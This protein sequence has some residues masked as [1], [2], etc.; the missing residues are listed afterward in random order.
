MAKR[1][2]TM[3]DSNKELAERKLKLLR[4]RQSLMEDLPHLYGW[5]WYKWAWDFFNSTNR[6]T[7][8]CA[9]NQISKSS[10]QIR[11]CIDWATNQEKWPSLWGRQ[12]NQFWYLYPSKEVATIEFEKKWLPEF[13]PRGAQKNSPYYGWTV[14]YDKKY[15]KA[16]HF[17]SGV[18]VY[19]KT[20][21]QDP[22]TL[23]SGSVYAIFCDEELPEH[24]YDELKF[25]LAG[26]RGFFH[27]VFTATLGQEMW[28]RAMEAIGNDNELFDTAWKRTISMYDCQTY[29]DGS[30]GPWTNERI[31][32]VIA[33][34]KSQAE[35]LRRVFGRFI[36][37]EGR[38][39]HAFDPTKHYVKPFKIPANWDRRVGVDIGSGGEEAHPSA[40]TFIAIRPDYQYGVIYKGW[41][42][43]GIQTTSGDV[44]DKFLEMKEPTEQFVNKVYDFAAKD[45]GT[46]TQRL[47]DS[48]N[49]AEKSHELGEDIINTLFK[50]N[51]LQIFDT[52]ELRK[53]G[54]EM[55]TLQ[56]STP[57]TKAKD[58]F[59]DS[60]RYPI[61]DAP[62]DFTAITP[63]D[64]SKVEE[65]VVKM[66]K[67][68][69]E[70][71]EYY[72]EERRKGFY[73]QRTASDDNWEYSLE[74]DVA[75]WNEQYGN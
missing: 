57:K 15:V 47:G 62:W 49:K 28:W 45:F 6:M 58:D 30:E 53:L 17:R 48:W 34:C 20:Y 69:Q 2:A 61:V 71:Q 19:F 64:D 8:L 24:L 27:M 42:G 10:T 7:L 68:A 54:N 38:K 22:K 14:E 5:P 4:E 43:D 33:D 63:Q 41:R 21:M 25:R 9:A 59:C 65:K 44:Y 66:P 18:S 60:A 3:N 70:W 37:D 67:T 74:S 39:Y 1:K 29:L 46:I 35:V 50:N 23:Q 52:D 11:K 32:E 26:T 40:I 12:P 55:I 16:I 72:I 56:K 36:K 75:F 73:D 13:M 31:D 51:M